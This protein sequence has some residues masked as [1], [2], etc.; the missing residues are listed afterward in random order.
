MSSG[1]LRSDPT[2]AAEAAA[3]AALRLW[4]RTALK[5]ES[6]RSKLHLVKLAFPQDRRRLSSLANTTIQPKATRRPLHPERT[7]ATRSARGEPPGGRGA[8]A[9]LAQ[10]RKGRGRPEPGA[11]RTPGWLQGS[12]S[13][14]E[15]KA[16]KVGAA[17]P[18]A[19]ANSNVYRRR[20]SAA[21]AGA[22]L[23][24]TRQHL[25]AH[26]PVRADSAPVL[27]SGERPD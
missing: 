26:S 11:P 27:K 12:A 15:R 22:A 6:E 4:P 8:R 2:S 17:S 20:P 24:S 3:P 21:G 5:Q 10:E 1:A 13:P 23:P 9:P 25:A 19:P 18:G 14:V 7:A 16:G